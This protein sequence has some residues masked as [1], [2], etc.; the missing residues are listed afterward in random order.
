MN[1]EAPWTIHKLTMFW[2]GRVQVNR[3]SFAGLMDAL[4][5]CAS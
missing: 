3:P 4:C 2:E 5:L 1:E